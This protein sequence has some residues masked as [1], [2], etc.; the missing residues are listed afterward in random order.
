[1]YPFSQKSLPSFGLH[2]KNP[3]VRLFDNVHNI[4]KKGATDI[5]ITRAIL[6]NL[7]I[8]LIQVCC[9][10]WIVYFWEAAG[11][12]HNFMKPIVFIP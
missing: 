12:L 10:T 1:M 9:F 11:I 4:S 7:H 5:D 3:L 2:N 8:V 6:I